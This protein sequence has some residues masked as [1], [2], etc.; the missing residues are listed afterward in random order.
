MNQTAID[1]V[2]MFAE[3]SFCIGCV[4]MGVFFVAETLEKSAGFKEYLTKDIE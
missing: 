1:N 3:Y 4:L 2:L